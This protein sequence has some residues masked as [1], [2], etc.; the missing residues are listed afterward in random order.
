MTQA[1]V[2]PQTGSPRV[3]GIRDYLGEQLRRPRIMLS[4][5]HHLDPGGPDHDPGAIAAGGIFTEAEWS[6][7]VCNAAAVL[8]G[9]WGYPVDLVDLPLSQTIR[10]AEVKRPA[11]LV[12]P[13]L[14]AGGG[15]RDYG[16]A[17]IYGATGLDD[18]PVTT[19]SRFAKEWLTLS[20]RWRFEN[21]LTTLAHI[22][23][24]PRDHGRKLGLLT[25]TPCPSCIT[26]TAFL[27]VPNIAEL[28][29]RTESI[30]AC[31]WQHAFAI[32]AVLP[33]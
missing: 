32:R 33:A 16:L 7:S 20:R 14:N 9:D 18:D 2:L 25:K 24:E 26:E 5:A 23:R 27:D 28:L 10:I 21:G 19:A 12:E 3:P 30:E 6:R 13:H 8:L 1:A 29:Q 17:I 31:A 11:L 4:V 15:G 22:W